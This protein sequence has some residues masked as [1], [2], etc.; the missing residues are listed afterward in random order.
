MFIFSYPPPPPLNKDG[1]SCGRRRDPI[2]PLSLSPP[3][4]GRGG[5]GEG[6]EEGQEEKLIGY[7]LLR[8]QSHFPPPPLSLNG[9]KG[10][11]G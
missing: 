7:L 3:D 4:D 6:I 10:E 2:S 8:I 5:E 11:G 9:G 1:S